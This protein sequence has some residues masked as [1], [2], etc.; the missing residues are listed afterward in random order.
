MAKRIKKSMK[1]V[2]LFFLVSC[3]HRQPGNICTKYHEKHSDDWFNCI[4]KIKKERSASI[5]NFFKG[6]EKRRQERELQRKEQDIEDRIQALE[7][8]QRRLEYKQRRL[9]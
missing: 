1:Y 8:K 2:L 5:D 7:Y 6:V 4:V 9:K 3:A